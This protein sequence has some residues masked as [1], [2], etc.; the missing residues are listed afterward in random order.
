MI[1]CLLYEAL[2]LRREEEI[3]LSEARRRAYEARAD[4]AAPTAA[5]RERRFAFLRRV[6]GRPRTA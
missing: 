6:A 1:E 5:P 2:R 3:R 4:A